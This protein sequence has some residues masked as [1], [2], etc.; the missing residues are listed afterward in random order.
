MTPGVSFR[1]A[2]DRRERSREKQDQPIL[3]AAV[4]SHYT[5]LLL[6]TF[7][8]FNHKKCETLQFFHFLILS[9]TALI[10]HYIIRYFCL[11]RPSSHWTGSSTRAGASAGGWNPNPY[12]SARPA[13]V[14]TV[15]LLS[16]APHR[17]PS[18]STPNNPGSRSTGHPKA[19]VMAVLAVRLC[20][21]DMN[22]ILEPVRLYWRCLVWL[23]DSVLRLLNQRKR[24]FYFT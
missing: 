14:H 1:R 16:G 9:S 20:S 15:H 5:A 22:A 10:T 11:L 8:S 17:T 12:N 18:Y 7:A 2:Q 24:D 6:H 21:Q 4:G 19:E 13:Q 23:T 3:P